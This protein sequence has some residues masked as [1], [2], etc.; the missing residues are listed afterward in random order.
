MRMN[1]SRKRINKQKRNVNL[2]M[3]GGFGTVY[4]CNDAMQMRF[5][6]EKLVNGAKNA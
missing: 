2:E 1:T 5:V 6:S 4:K 3:V